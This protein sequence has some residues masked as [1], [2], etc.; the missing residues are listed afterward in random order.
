MTAL[1]LLAAVLVV[2]GVVSGC[3]G[4]SASDKAKKQ[5]CD[6]RTDVQKQVQSLQQLP[7]STSSIA[8]AQGSLTAIKDDI[9][10]IAGAQDELS[11]DRKQQVQSATGQFK[12]QL[13]DI[14]NGLTQN[15]SLA[16]AQQQ[17]K[18]ATAKLVSSYKQT[19]GRVN[20]S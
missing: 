20:C 12:T 18:T 2:A 1:R 7:L 9:Q 3:G 17:V 13:Q 5:V 14:A 4:Q 8:A 11:S 6:A 15:L 19:L 10:A 16:N